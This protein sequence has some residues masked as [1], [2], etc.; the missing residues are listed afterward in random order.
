M[1]QTTLVILFLPNDDDMVF[2]AGE[3]LTEG[4]ID[5][6]LQG[7]E[8]NS[9]KVNYEGKRFRLLNL[10]RIRIRHLQSVSK[11]LLFQAGAVHGIFRIHWSCFS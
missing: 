2:H 7:M 1:G 3:R 8:D 9:G 10:M 4:D 6:L 11:N 5:T